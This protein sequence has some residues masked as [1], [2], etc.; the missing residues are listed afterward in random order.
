MG[1]FFFVYGYGGTGKTFLWN[2]L[3]TSIRSKGQIV[4]NVASSEIATLLLPNG[5]TAHSRFKVLLSVNQDSICNIRQGMPL[6]H[7]ISSLKLIIWDEAPML[8]KFFYEALDKCPKDVLRFNHGSKPDAL[9]GGKVVV[10][11]VLPGVVINRKHEAVWGPQDHRSVE[12]KKFADWLLQLGDGL[13]GDSIDGESVIRIPDKL[14]LDI[15]LPA[16]HDLVLFVYP[17]VLLHISSV[18]Y[19]KDRSIL[20]PT[21]D[22]V[23]K[24]NNHV[25]SLLPGNEKVYLSSDTLLNEDGHLESELYTMSTESLNALNC[26]GILVFHNT[27][28]EYLTTGDLPEDPKEAKYLKR[29][30]T[31][32]T[33]IVGQLYKRGLSQPLLK[34]I[35]LGQTDYILREIHE[36][37]CGHHVRGKTLA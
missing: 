34:C 14:L 33:T 6:A 16:L 18:D 12:L 9:F 2:S 30:A 23:M 32:Y 10:L 7:L 31:K 13:L 37:C 11:G 22:V 29:D 28:Q 25:M 20:A 27:G 24:V 3:S 26:S 36:G 5:R 35:K 1:G 17:D 8:N 19:F 15:E 4:L 21:L